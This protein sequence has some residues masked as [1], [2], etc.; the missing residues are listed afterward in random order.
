MKKDVAVIGA[1]PAGIAAAIQLKKNNIDFLLFEKD[2][3]GGLLKNAHRVENYPG[4]PN[5]IPGPQLVT[6]LREHLDA[7]G[8]IPLYETVSALEYLGEEKLFLITTPTSAHYSK[9][10]VVASGTSPRRINTL[11]A[12]PLPLRENIFYDIL[13][14]IKER[15]KRI[16][17][18]GA[19]DEAFDYALNLGSYNNEVIIAVPGAAA[20]A[21]PRLIDKVAA[22]PRIVCSKNVEITGITAGNTKKLRITFSARG[23]RTAGEVDYLLVV[24]GR[25]SQRVFYN[26]LLITQAKELK[27]AGRL[28]EIGDMVNGIYRQTAIACGDGIRAALQ[29]AAHLRRPLTSIKI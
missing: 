18:V 3:A 29:I 4:F 26:P 12:L 14:I 10:V 9:V 2:Q 27:N 16:L 8:V 19:D 5:G 25:E 22:N 28:Y 24:A 13:P 17:I 6:L 15:G 1:G 23:E 21:V 11:D 7:S 20:K